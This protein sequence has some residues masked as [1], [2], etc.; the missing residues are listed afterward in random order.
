MNTRLQVEHPITELVTGVDL[1]K[2]QIRVAAGEP[3]PFRQAD[4]SQ[5]GHAIECRIYA[6]DP[7]N[8]FLP[9]TGKVLRTELP[10]APGVRVD[11]GITSGDEVTRH[12][13]PLIAKLSVL[14]ANRQDAI[15]K[16]AWA[17]RHCVILGEVT[18]N[19]LFLRSL[20][21]HPSFQQGETTTDFVE[22]AFANWQ[23]DQVAPP[24]MI[25]IAAA[26]TEYM[27]KARPMPTVV[28]GQQQDDPYNPWRSQIGFRVGAA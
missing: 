15:A 24:D 6:E 21:S 10:I 17:L 14:D 27:D 22:Q 12:Y 7:A 2:T 1:V 13:D 18:T 19:V 20:L 3:L 26:L 28:N 23:P 8:H 9:V 5:R 4:L 11:T 16:M 25:L